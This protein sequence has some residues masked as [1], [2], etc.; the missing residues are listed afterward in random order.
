MLTGNYARKGRKT[1][2]GKDW[3]LYVC[4]GSKERFEELVRPY[5]LKTMLYKLGDHSDSKEKS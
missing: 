4:K 5:M 1:F 3:V 2:S